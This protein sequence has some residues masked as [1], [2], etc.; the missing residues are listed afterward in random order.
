M[1]KTESEW[2]GC[3]QTA[4][5]LGVTA[6]TIWRW[7]RDPKLAFPASTVIHGRKYWSR[8]D[9]D[10]W[11]RRMATG[12]ASA[13]EKSRVSVAAQSDLTGGPLAESGSQS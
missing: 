5:Y 6:M 9:I 1:S 11:M 13:T 8:D 12:K 3:A 10:A 2:L 4:A 7:E